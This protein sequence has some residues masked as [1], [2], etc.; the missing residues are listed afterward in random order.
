VVHDSARMAGCGCGVWW[1]CSQWQ[2]PVSPWWMEQ[3]IFPPCSWPWQVSDGQSA[4]VVQVSA[5][6]AGCGCGVWWWCSQW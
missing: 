6:I 3:I 1:W 2:T 5:R 4:A